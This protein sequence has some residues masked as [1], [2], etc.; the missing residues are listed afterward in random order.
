MQVALYTDRGCSLRSEA[1]IV[2]IG[3][4]GDVRVSINVA[5]DLCIVTFSKGEI[6]EIIAQAIQNDMIRKAVLSFPNVKKFFRDRE[7]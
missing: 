3:V 2:D 6:A 4:F 5:G 1:M 7:D